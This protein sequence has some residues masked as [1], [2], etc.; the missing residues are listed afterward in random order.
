M[1]QNENQWI[2]L[3]ANAGI[4]F[5]Y[6]LVVATIIALTNKDLR[7]YIKTCFGKLKRL[8]IGRQDAKSNE[9]PTAKN[10]DNE[11]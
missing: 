1:V 9:E 3:F 4:S 5:A 8:P 7:F 6:S 11:A 10:E 2:E